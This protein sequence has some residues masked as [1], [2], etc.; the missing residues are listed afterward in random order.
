MKENVPKI[1]L[2]VAIIVLVILSVLF[3]SL[4]QPNAILAMFAVVVLSVIYL[5][6]MEKNH[7]K[8]MHHRRHS[9]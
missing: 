2:R 9:E 6:G 4:N 5:G 7:E 3:Y 1:T 8:A